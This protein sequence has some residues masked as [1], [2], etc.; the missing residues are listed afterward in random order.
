MNKIIPWIVGGM[1]L[2][3]LVVVGVVFSTSNRPFSSAPEIINGIT[4]PPEP[5]VTLNNATLA[6]VDS[7]NNGV[8][9][10]VERKIATGF[11][12]TAD[13]PISMAYAREYQSVLLAPTPSTRTAA[14]VQVSKRLC[15][16]RG[17]SQELLNFGVSRLID[18]TDQRKHA[19]RY[20]ND[21]LT[22]YTP[23]EL[24]PC[25]D[26]SHTEASSSLQQDITTTTDIIN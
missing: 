4:V 13:Y 22:G 20:L 16:L 14:L 12:G 10:D 24:P 3:V 23:M 1:A 15:A 6:G 9:D 17:A 25:E 11:G 7:N 2:L 19:T 21:V 26:T 8:R 5:D 18:N